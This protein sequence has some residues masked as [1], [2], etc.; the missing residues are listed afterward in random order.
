MLRV[1]R[2][3]IKQRA[4]AHRV[5]RRHLHRAAHRRR[6]DRRRSTRRPSRQSASPRQEGHARRRR[7]GPSSPRTG[8]HPAALAPHN[9]CQHRFASPDRRREQMTGERTRAVNALTSLLRT[10]DLGVDAR[11]A[12]TTRTLTTIAAWRSRDEDPHP[13]SL[14]HRNHPSGPAHPSPRRQPHRPARSRRHQSTTPA[15]PTRRRRRRRGDRPAGLVTPDASAPKPPSPARHHYRPRQAT[16]PDTDST[17][18]AT[19]LLHR[20]VTFEMAC[21]GGRLEGCCCAQA[22]PS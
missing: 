5:L 14:R 9:R 20:Q 10:V 15:R 13:D 21:P 2:A 18:A 1:L 11:R 3:R 6:P 17:A 19:G 16:P 12:L 7:K 22:L 4:W 8:R